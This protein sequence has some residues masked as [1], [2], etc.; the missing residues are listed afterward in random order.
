M[1]PCLYAFM[2]GSFACGPAHEGFPNGNGGL[3]D[4]SSPLF[5]I[6]MRELTILCDHAA[7]ARLRGNV[8]AWPLLG[9]GRWMSLRRSTGRRKQPCP[10][11]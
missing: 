7:Q 4:N 6:P 1:P 2:P 9:A 5:S 8:R 3:H 11:R 10:K